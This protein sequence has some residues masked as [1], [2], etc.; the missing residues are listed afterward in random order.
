[1]ATNSA[2]SISDSHSSTNSPPDLDASEL[3]EFSDSQQSVKLMHSC[4]ACRKKK[5]KC[6]GSKP[7]CSTCS[8]MSIKCIYSP[9][10][11]K[12]KARKSELQ[13]IDS[14]LL[15]IEQSFID[16][17]KI[18]HEVVRNE[19]SFSSS[20]ST[21]TPSGS[22]SLQP[23]ILSSN[24][25]HTTF[26]QKSAEQ[27]NQTVLAE[28]FVM[29]KEF[30]PSVFLYVINDISSFSPALSLVTRIPILLE[31]LA[32]DEI[33][34]CYIFSILALGYFSLVNICPAA[35]S[36][37]ASTFAIA[38]A[39]SFKRVSDETDTHLILSATNLCFYYT[40]SFEFEAANVFLGIALRGIEK[41]LVYQ[42]DE[43]YCGFKRVYKSDVVDKEFKRRLW[44]S[45]Y[46]AD[47]S[48]TVFSPTK[49]MF[50]D[51]DT[52]VN[53]PSNDF[54][55]KYT[56]L[57]LD[58]DNINKFK[59]SILQSINSPYQPD[60]NWLNCKSYIILSK[61]FEFVNKRPTRYQNST[62]PDLDSF[63]GI[64]NTDH[65]SDLFQ[66]LD[67]FNQL[68]EQNLKLVPFNQ[69]NDALNSSSDNAL[70][71][72][73]AFHSF[74]LRIIPMSL[75][76]ILL[77][78]DITEYKVEKVSTKRVIG[79]KKNAIDMSIGILTLIRWFNKNM[80][81]IA[82]P[83]Q[84]SVFM[85]SAGT[86][87]LNARFIDDHPKIDKIRT[88][89]E[90]IYE[91]LFR[92]S[93]EYKIAKNYLK[94]LKE[95]DR[96][97]EL[98][99]SF[100]RKFNKPFLNT[101]KTK[102]LSEFDEIP[103]LVFPTSTLDMLNFNRLG[104]HEILNSDYYLS[105]NLLKYTPEVYSM[106]LNER[107]INESQSSVSQQHS[108]TIQEP[109]TNAMFNFQRINNLLESQPFGYIT[110]EL[111]QNSSM[112]NNQPLSSL[113]SSTNQQSDTS[114]LEASMLNDPNS[115]TDTI[116]NPSAD[117]Y[118]PFTADSH[119]SS[120]NDTLPFA[121]NHIS[122]RS[123]FGNLNKDLSMRNFSASPIPSSV[124]R[125]FQNFRPSS[126][127][128]KNTGQFNDS[129]YLNNL[130]PIQGQKNV[131]FSEN[132][133]S[134]LSN[135]PPSMNFSND[136]YNTAQ[137]TYSTDSLI[138]S[139][140]VLGPASVDTSYSNQF[141][142]HN[143]SYDDFHTAMRDQ[144]DGSAQ[145]TYQRQNTELDI[146]MGRKKFFYSEDPNSPNTDNIPNSNSR[147]NHS[148][149]DF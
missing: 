28:N 78:S 5:V 71:K 134:F 19:H 84:S 17:A 141:Q 42:I 29:S 4:D 72:E 146:E 145:G 24:H 15:S 108:R 129:Q 30:T 44:W 149:S 138:N 98:Q 99:V 11:K 92:L 53:F 132:L 25:T 61:V 23:P 124:Q 80:N 115:N 10:S 12:K 20:T 111:A 1:M 117:F 123:N 51:D 100:V 94:L 85:F 21:F 34:H 40:Y 52:S 128:H 68:V 54:L 58:D 55:F 95:M 46:M 7:T 130:Y 102:Q 147:A 22:N 140:S 122:S 59:N 112:S 127:E 2:R 60:W 104:V 65:I 90:S 131:V 49:P 13:K 41:T 74:I 120:R 27:C 139:E 32:K 26:N 143:Y 57:D 97:R 73:I 91:E 31:Q 62:I 105:Q 110:P 148:V 109:I 116:V 106:I 136:Y 82:P 36:L 89:L 70:K 47:K 119:G 8:R 135:K 126:A 38:S 45:F 103:W 83:I 144:N 113:A 96:R 75:T 50:S 14:I 79:S 39:N 81:G 121:S 18:A 77:R 107:R 76:V 87:L 35:S 63:D 93:H 67:E 101:D 133:S 69:C 6:N 118:F 137:S 43:H 3:S 125:D 37:S 56:S 86:I 48:M 66:E 64:T 88:S 16:L 9:S 142:S 114:S 33:P